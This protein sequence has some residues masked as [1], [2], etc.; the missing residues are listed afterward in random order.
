MYAEYA[1]KSNANL[2]DIYEDIKKILT[3]TTDKLTLSPSCDGVKTTINTAYNVAGWTFM[4]SPKSFDEVSNQSTIGYPSTSYGLFY[5]PTLNM[6]LSNYSSST[7]RS[8]DSITWTACNTLS[9]VPYNAYADNGVVCFA[10]YQS[11]NAGWWSSDGITWTAPTS[12]PTGSQWYCIAAVQNGLFVIAGNSWTCATS[13][14]NG[15]TWVNKPLSSYTGATG[16]AY[17][18]ACGNGKIMVV[19][20]TSIS[21]ISADNGATWT[22]KSVPTTFHQVVYGNGM[23]LAMSSSSTTACIYEDSA[24]AWTTISLPF[25][26][27]S[28]TKLIFD[29]TNSIFIAT[30]NTT[31][32]AFS[33]DGRTWLTKA[34]TSTF[35]N[36]SMTTKLGV[37]YCLYGGGNRITKYLCNY[38]SGA[39]RSS[40]LLT[41]T[42]KYMHI[43]LGNG[44]GTRVI[45]RGFETLENG[46]W[47]NMMYSS[48]NLSLNQ[49][50]D[51]TYGGMIYISASN[52]HCAMYSYKPNSTTWGSSNGQ[53]WTA[54]YEYTRDDL[55][56]DESYPTHLW[57]NGTFHANAIYVSRLKTGI[58]VDSISS[59]ASL[60]LVSD[61][62]ITK[63]L[64][65]S[66]GTG[67]AQSMREMRVYSN[68]Y[69][70]Y[71]VNGGKVLGD[72]WET[73]NGYGVNLQ[74][75]I[76]GLKTYVVWANSS[77][78]YLYPKG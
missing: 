53:G 47:T 76:V 30:I 62:A 29:S 50:I 77:Y 10:T 22:T 1:Y 57:V 36:G 27:Q 28:G 19:G 71:L 59:N 54:I 9:S 15:V 78:R 65:D 23:F 13:V 73:T 26:Y 14:N 35:E 61:Y 72:V 60:T 38:M 7:Y 68:S 51:L 24:N 64:L 12:Q 17:S 40:N 63:P 34:F 33:A 11:S 16:V 42:Y 56:N 41:N 6:F 37:L 4:S 25:T 3:G 69:T 74:E 46:S 44:A 49:Q 43:D 32:L 5:S 55:W 18:I 48:D 21:A 70:T 2:N 45:M 52:R 58:G 31:I 66:S 39:F 75:A 20:S 8:T 67:L